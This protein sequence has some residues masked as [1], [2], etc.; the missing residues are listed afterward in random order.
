ML[1]LL[2]NV[3]F[4]VLLTLVLISL[5]IKNYFWSRLLGETCADL[6]IALVAGATVAYGFLQEITLFFIFSIG[7]ACFIVAGILLMFFAESVLIKSGFS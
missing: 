6:G 1:F 4:S 5:L 3:F 2:A 7:G